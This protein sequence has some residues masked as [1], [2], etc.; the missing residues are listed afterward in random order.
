MRTSFTEEQLKDKDNRS[1]EAIIRKCSSLWFF[2]FQRVP[3]I[4]F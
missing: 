1:S 3:H 4:K 2:V